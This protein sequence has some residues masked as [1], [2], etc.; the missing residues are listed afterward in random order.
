[1]TKRHA[2]MSKQVPSALDEFL[3]LLVDNLKRMEDQIRLCKSK[4]FRP[5]M[6]KLDHFLLTTEIDKETPD[7]LKDGILHFPSVF[8]LSNP[9]FSVA[10]F[11]FNAW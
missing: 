9:V 3:N 2:T 6:V 10:P 8:I 4:C 7:K 1:M 11:F 5:M